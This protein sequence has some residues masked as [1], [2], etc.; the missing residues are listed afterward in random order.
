MAN[1]A[2]KYVPPKQQRRHLPS[3][4]SHN[5]S[6]LLVAYR[7]R[8]FRVHPFVVKADNWAELSQRKVIML[9]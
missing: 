8:L 7:W 4:L 2:F 9:I 6:S 3:L 1:A 5:S